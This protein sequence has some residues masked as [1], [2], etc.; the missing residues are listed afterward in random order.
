MG[1][2]SEP[3][4]GMKRAAEVSEAML[5][6]PGYADDSI[7]FTVRYGHRAKETLRKRDY[8]ELMETLNKMTVLWSKSGGGGAKPGPGAEE[9]HAQMMELR[10]H[11]FEII[12][13]FPDL[14]RDFDRF[15][16]SS[17]AAMSAVMRA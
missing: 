4:S 15:H 9:R 1:Q 10:G 11:C 3:D 8:E 5:S 13:D 7:F 17:R 12:K 14:V 6:V 16:A 2:T